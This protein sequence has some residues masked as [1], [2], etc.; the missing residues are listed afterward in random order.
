MTMHQKSFLADVMD[1]SKKIPKGKLAYFRERQRNR[2]Y[3]FIIG[4][5][6]EK[7]QKEGLTKAA[8]AKRMHRRPEQV[9]RWLNSPGNWTLDT[10]SDLMLAI[11]GGEIRFS[12]T[13]F[14][15]MKLRNINQLEHLNSYRTFSTSAKTNS[16]MVV[17]GQ[18]KNSKD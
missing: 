15:H 8:L 6:L 1:P 3:D 12:E 13:I 16:I 4:H 2:L 10:L 5:F 14:S 18:E 9:T 17:Y 11:C 7:E